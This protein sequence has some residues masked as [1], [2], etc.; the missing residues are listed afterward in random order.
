M[1]GEATQHFDVMNPDLLI[2][3]LDTSAKLDIELTVSK[4]TW[5]CSC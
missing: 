2:C 4:R 5:L 3:T 1:I